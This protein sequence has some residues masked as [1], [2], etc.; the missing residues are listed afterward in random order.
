MRLHAILHA[1]FQRRLPMA[2]MHSGSLEAVKPLSLEPHVA[3]RA[4]VGR[5]K[6]A[7]VKSLATVREFNNSSAS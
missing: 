3:Q 1:N 7:S 2:H 5:N 4:M 6:G